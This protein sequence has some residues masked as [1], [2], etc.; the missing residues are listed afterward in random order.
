MVTG[1]LGRNPPETCDGGGVFVTGG[2]VTVIAGMVVRPP[3]S[4]TVIAGIVVN[5]PGRVTVAPG[6]WIVTVD[7]TVDVVAFAHPLI[8][9]AA[10]HTKIK[11]TDKD[12]LRKL[13]SPFMQFSRS[14]LCRL[15]S[16]MRE[17]AELS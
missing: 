1:V 7:V 15:T 11:S 17:R 8:S 6:D 10:R 12:L 2:I 4:V 13:F 14:R 3:G 9:I 5:P 16:I